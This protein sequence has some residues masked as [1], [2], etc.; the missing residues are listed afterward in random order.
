MIAGLARENA[1]L[2]VQQAAIRTLVVAHAVMYRIGLPFGQVHLHGRMQIDFQDISRG[3]QQGIHRHPPTTE[4]IV[5][6]QDTRPVQGNVGI[7]VQA[8]EAQFRTRVRQ[9]GI[10]HVERARIDP[11][12]LVHPLHGA[13]AETHKGVVDEAGGHKVGMY[14]PRY[15]C[16]IGLMPAGLPHLPGAIQRKRPVEIGKSRSRPAQERHS[17][18]EKDSFHINRRVSG[19][20]VRDGR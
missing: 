1:D 5:C 11:V 8:V 17:Q 20:S 4:H 18:E 12:L 14:G 2:P 3:F 6:L 15:D 13:L 10:R 19:N 7:G 9:Q 16:R